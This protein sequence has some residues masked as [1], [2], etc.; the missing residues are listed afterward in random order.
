MDLVDFKTQTRRISLFCHF[1]FSCINTVYSLFYRMHTKKV[2]VL[3]QFFGYSLQGDCC[4]REDMS[5]RQSRRK[6]ATRK[7]EKENE[8]AEMKKEKKKTRV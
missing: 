7:K 3:I 8:E 2:N 6:E 4:Y 1:F 5:R